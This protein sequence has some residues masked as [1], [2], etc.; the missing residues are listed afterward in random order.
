MI[1]EDGDVQGATEGLYSS[2]YSSTEKTTSSEEIH[3]KPVGKHSEM[4]TL[5]FSNG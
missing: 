2:T 4:F 1:C 3:L 5:G